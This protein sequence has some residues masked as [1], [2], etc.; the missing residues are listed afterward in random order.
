MKVHVLSLFPRLFESFLDESI[1]GIARAKGLLEVELHDY[2]EATTDRHNTVDD[3]PYGGGP[4]MV[5]KPEPVFETVE[6]VLADAGRP[7]MPKLLLT[8]TGERFDQN[9]A[10]ELSEEPEWLVLCGRY[11]GFDQRIHDG[12]DWREISL[13][14]FVLSGGEIPAMAMI[15]ASTRLI[16]NVLGHDE[17]AQQDSFTSGQL[18][19][20]HYTRP[21]EFRGSTVP[22]ILL[23]GHHS[24]IEAWRRQQA[25]RRTALWKAHRKA[26]T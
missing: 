5:I 7:T 14:D 19:Y 9:I 2:R 1:V 12:F 18:D 20:P 22:D 23:S 10:A 6:R 8:P 11:E 24:D 21:Y 25:E 13:G 15:E 16:P 17:S 3:R 26:H 4:G